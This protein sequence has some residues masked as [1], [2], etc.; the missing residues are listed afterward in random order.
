MAQEGKLVEFV[1]D[2]A[3]YCKGDIVRLDSEAVKYVSA[4]AKKI[5]LEG[6]VYKASTAK[7]TGVDRTV[8]GET[9]VVGATA[10]PEDPTEVDEPTTVH[11]GTV[12]NEQDTNDEK[13][14]PTDKEV[15]NRESDK[16]PR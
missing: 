9:P 6:D 4:R 16:N 11:G 12:L 8:G 3:P 5:G 14:K 10:A 7:D 1:Q 2:C 15:K 13:L